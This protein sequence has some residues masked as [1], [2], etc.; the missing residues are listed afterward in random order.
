MKNLR[1]YRQATE[2]GKI[3]ECITSTWDRMYT[4]LEVMCCEELMDK[5]ISCHYSEQYLFH[6][7]IIC[8]NTN[9]NV[10]KF[11]NEIRM[12]SINTHLFLANSYISAMSFAK[13]V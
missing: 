4:I 8:S 5:E 6:T 3:L 13:N 1:H 7:C 2:R 10:Y 9:I 11:Q 12:S